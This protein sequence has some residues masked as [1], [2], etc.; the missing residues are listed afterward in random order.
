MKI[1]TFVGI[2]NTKKTLIKMSVI[3]VILAYFGYHAVSGDSGVVAYMRLKKQVTEKQEALDV[4][5]KEFQ[6]LERKV[7]LLSDKSLD[8]DLLEERCRSIN[9]LSEAGDLIVKVY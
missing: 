2:S 5:K 1:T 9:N 3:A 7:K 8:L 4:I 6:S